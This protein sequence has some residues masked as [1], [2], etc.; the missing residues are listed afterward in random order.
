MVAANRT[1]NIIIE[2]AYCWTPNMYPQARAHVGDSGKVP[3]PAS[4]VPRLEFAVSRPSH[5]ILRSLFNIRLRPSGYSKIRVASV[6]W[7]SRATRHDV[8]ESAQLK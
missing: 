8:V 5:N 6:F 7:S 1:D 4:S 2:S 3:R